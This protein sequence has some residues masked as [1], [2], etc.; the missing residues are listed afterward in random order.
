M[1]ANVLFIMLFGK[2]CRSSL[3]KVVVQLIE[4]NCFPAL[5]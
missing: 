1:P 3:E 5:L 4:S 2:L